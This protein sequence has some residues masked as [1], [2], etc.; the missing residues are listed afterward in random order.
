MNKQRFSK[1]E[2]V[3]LEA[4]QLAPEVFQGRQGEYAK[5][6]VNKIVAEGYDKS[7]EPIVLW[8]SSEESNILISGHSRYEAAKRLFDLGDLSLS[9]VPAK[10]FLGS[11][12]EA[13]EYALLESNRSGTGEGLL[14]DI[15]AYQ[16][17][18]E[19]GKNKD[20]LKH[21]FKPEAHLRLVAGLAPLN[22]NGYFVQ[23]LVSDAGKQFPYLKRNALWVGTIRKQEP[24]L[25]HAHED[26]LFFYLYPI[27]KGNV[28]RLK[29]TKDEFF[30]AVDLKL[31]RI[32]FD[33]AM[34]LNLDEKVSSSAITNPI[35]EQINEL[36]REVEKLDKE[37]RDKDQRIS[38]ARS[39][40]RQ[41]LVE[42]HQK[43]SSEI[44]QLIARILQE[45]RSL[46]E[47][48]ARTR[49]ETTIDLFSTPA[50]VTPIAPS[51]NPDD[52]L[53][54]DIWYEDYP[55]NVLG[56]RRETTDRFGKPTF[57]IVGDNQI[58]LGKI[59][60][61]S[62]TSPVR[63]QVYQA[64]INEAKLEMA[65]QKSIAQQ[66]KA[67]LKRELPDL[68]QE[69]ELRSFD[70]VL[71]ELNPELSRE[72]IQVWLWCQYQYGTEQMR[73]QI[74]NK[75]N[76]WEQF[77]PL[78][79]DQERLV[80]QWVEKG[81]LCFENKKYIPAPVYYSGDI[82]KRVTQLKQKKH[83]FEQLHGLEQYQR[84]LSG[85]QQALPEKLLLKT[86]D[87]S[88]KLVLTLHSQFCQDIEIASLA[89]GTE[90]TTQ[91]KGGQTP[92]AEPKSLLWAFSHW[93]S[94]LP[95]SEFKKI[96]QLEIQAY[97]IHKNNFSRIMT[98]D[99]KQRIRRLTKLEG[100]KFFARFLSQGLGREDQLRIET[101]WN[102][103]FNS[104]VEVDYSKIPVAFSCSS[105]FRNKPLQL[106]QVQR[107]GVAYMINR[108]SGCIAYDVGL[109]KTMT[110][111]CAMAQAMEM[112]KCSRPLIVVPN[113]TYENW[114][115][116]IQGKIEGGKI[117]QTGILPQYPINGLYNLSAPYLELVLD[118]EGNVD[119]VPPQSITIVTYQG[120]ARLGFREQTWNQMG[121]ELYGIL[122]Q[123]VESQR[124]EAQLQE[125]IQTMMGVGISGAQVAIEDL[126]FD[127]L[128]VD[129][130]HAMKKSFTSVKGEIRGKKREKT[131][132]KIQS[133]QPSSTALRG[134]MVSRYLQSG[135]NNGN[136]LLLTATPFT[137]S[138]LEIYSMLALIAYPELEKAGIHNLKTFFDLFIRTS[139]EL[140]IGANLRPMR[141]EL[142]LSFNNLRAL[143]SLIFRFIRFKSGEEA[144][145]KRP[146]KIVLPRLQERVGQ[147]LV[148]LPF[149]D[150]IETFLPFTSTQQKYMDQIE[151]Y[152]LGKVLLG[153]FG[154]DDV[155]LAEAD[156][157]SARTL[158]A[159]GYASQVCLSPFL[160][161]FHDG[162]APTPKTYVEESPKIHY[163]VR[164]IESVRKHAKSTGLNMPGQV[165]YM[166]SGVKYFPLILAYLKE[167]SGFEDKELGMITGGM[168]AKKKERIKN[169]FLSGE[170]KVLLG[171]AAI[172][173]GIN[174]Q[175]KATD[176]YNLWLDWN[177][178]DVRQL[179]GRIWRQGN[180]YT[181]VRV[182]FPLMSNSVDIFRFQKLQEKTSR[183]NAIWKRQDR[184]NT[185]NL[186]AFNP[187]ELKTA[188][189]HDPERIA[190][191]QVA[192]EKERLI[193]E[194]QYQGALR[195]YVGYYFGAK[196]KFEEHYPYVLKTANRYRPARKG[197][198][199]KVETVLSIFDD[200]LKDPE[201]EVLYSDSD[202][203][204]EVRKSYRLM[205]YL[206]RDILTPNNWA[207]EDK[208]YINQQIEHKTADLNR[209]KE[210]VSGEQKIAMLATEIIEKR[211]AEKRPLVTIKDAVARFATLNDKVIGE[212]AFVPTPE[213]Q[214]ETPAEE[215]I[216]DDFKAIDE[217][218]LILEE[219]IAIEEEM[220]Q[221]KIA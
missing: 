68:N 115:A 83:G 57:R 100:E 1:T 158:R 179:E 153:R 84:Q 148:D 162:K 98:K 8:N 96:S 39:L 155:F 141:K 20:Y 208:K 193:E 30:K 44:T 197:A 200:W 74:G 168:D 69:M 48:I 15:L 11:E 87:P 27:E 17:A 107:E 146:H 24:R 192:K 149:E 106:R 150:R 114:I 152:L 210:D 60:A 125:R 177:P 172:R 187:E 109:G 103:L 174:L 185:L 218:I 173:E 104:F 94:S 89:D 102:N 40:D 209:Q 45:K 2:E 99:E 164:C 29:I 133:G 10:Y 184:E 7:Q 31:S 9:A 216:E 213:P 16:R 135:N 171:S 140:V 180:Q 66:S 117:V 178:T 190:Q 121:A 217:A 128:I 131:P 49:R 64:P 92:Q 126:G 202:R 75:E 116:E 5:E 67:G 4:I 219:L 118:S 212:L 176:I 161:E 90:F 138:P 43:R 142:V 70:E 42:K 51:R 61:Q 137:N 88:R 139:N 169:R 206:D 119:G 65:I 124:Q 182:T 165:I 36:D 91:P 175:Y 204:K 159:V 86:D 55:A 72:E 111:I 22:P 26:E 147:T 157:E 195:N 167:H 76:G 163:A 156:Q 81:L 14:S 112:G 154:E 136:V 25:S 32:D 47:S 186:E 63:S 56:E 198:S 196:N 73:E 127:Y 95:L 214:T 97:Y 93:L 132:Y 201:T 52:Y 194:I 50:P 13:V 144:N 6:T 38:R 215:T 19:L 205:Q 21:F 207:G 130:A 203:L 58:A 122:N 79:K 54:D 3:Q 41:D 143:Q 211:E 101:K 151:G 12:E 134:F 181:N 113:S 170:I 82:H 35:R 123:G 166:N 188:L 59:K 220:N 105:T 189:I 85:L 145:I 191:M 46:E 78:L 23:Q 18:L 33:P 80:A 129:E 110:A 28:S 108:G 199:R 77:L 120:F 71:D 37:R 183:I 34:P 62:V 221:L 160:Y 53:H